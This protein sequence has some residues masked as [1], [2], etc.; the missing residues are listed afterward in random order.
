[1][2]YKQNKIKWIKLL[3]LIPSKS[4]L[5]FRNIRK[6]GEINRKVRLMSCARSNNYMVQENGD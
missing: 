5:D 4:K 1:M 3:L 6:F 2:R